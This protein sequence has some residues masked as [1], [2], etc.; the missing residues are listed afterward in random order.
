MFA[1]RLPSAVEVIG[2]RQPVS[3]GPVRDSELH[4]LRPLEPEWQSDSWNEKIYV[5]TNFEICI[6]RSV[7]PSR[8]T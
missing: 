5:K 3:P 8:S 7:N 4:T 2:H 6:L 1:A